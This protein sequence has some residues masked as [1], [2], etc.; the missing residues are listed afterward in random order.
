[1]RGFCYLGDRVNASG[2]CKAA[3]TARAR[4]GWVKFREY[5]ELLNSKRLSLKMK[6]MVYRSYVRL[7]MLYGRTEDLMEML[8]LKET[9]VHMANANGVRWY[10]H[11]LRRDDGHFL[12]KALEFEL[13]GKRKRGRPKKTWKTQVQKEGK[14][15]GL[16]KKDAMNRARWRVGVREI[17]AKL[18]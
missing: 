6:E 13:K 9:V 4:I 2:G 8:G 15:V 18:G 10:G 12:R 5:G 11:V 17:A 16:E 14:S 1:M 3:V 7:A